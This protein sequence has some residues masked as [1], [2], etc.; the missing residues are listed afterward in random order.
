MIALTIGIITLRNKEADSELTVVA[1]STRTGTG[2]TGAA[3]TLAER[4]AELMSELLRPIGAGA[5]D[6]TDITV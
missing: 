1:L 5:S 4:G 3:T 2:S 6:A